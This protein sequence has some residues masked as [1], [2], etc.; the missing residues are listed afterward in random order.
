MNGK[1]CCVTGHRTIPASQTAFVKQTL[2][3]EIALAVAEGFTHFL[4]GFAEGADL[5]F[6]E[7]AAE[8]CA[9]RAEVCLEAAIPYRGRLNR[10]QKQEE[11][12][13]LLQSCGKITVVSEDYAPNVYHKR[14][15]YMVERSER[16]LAVYDGRQTGGTAA[17]IRMA[18]K[19]GAELRKIFIGEIKKE[20]SCR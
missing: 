17:T 18:E 16:V 7:I 5:L 10:L 19:K 8:F 3:A 2:R 11:T 9:E 12:R 13:R 14:N 15:W 6:A 1:T 20:E 4:S